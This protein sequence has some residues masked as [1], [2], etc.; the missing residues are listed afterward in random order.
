MLSEKN[1][2]KISDKIAEKQAEAEKLNNLLE[3]HTNAYTYNMDQKEKMLEKA[4]NAHSKEERQ[5]YEK[6]AKRY[7]SM[8][9]NDYNNAS[10]VDNDIANTEKS[11]DK[12]KSKLNKEKGT[13]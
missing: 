1:K 8:A 5:K 13:R 10:A 11:I 2:K 9:N 12:L 4:K 3:A 7:E 6:E